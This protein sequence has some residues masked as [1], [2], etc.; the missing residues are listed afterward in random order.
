MPDASHHRRTKRPAPPGGLRYSRDGEKGYRREPSGKSFAY[1]DSGDRRV[2]DEATLERI[3]SLAIPPAWTRVWICGDERGHLQ[4]TGRDAR[5][6]KQYRYHP[7]WRELRDADKFDHLIEFAKAL[8][9]IRRQA[10]SDIGAAGLPRRKVLALLVELLE[11]T[12]IRVGN[13]RYAEENE[14]FGLTTMRNRHVKV[15]GARIEFQFRGKSGKFHR[16]ALDDPKLARIV[17]RIRELPGQELFQYLDEAGEVQSVGSSDVNEYLKEIS[18]RDV[19]TKDFRTWAGS[20]YV[21]SLLRRR[22]SVGITHV[23]A[24]VREASRQLGNTPAICRKSY[25]HPRVLDPKTW[26]ARHV[27]G[28]S[29]SPRGLRVEEAAFL[30]II[31]PLKPASRTVRPRTPIP[32]RAAPRASSDRP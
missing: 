21:A 28:A 10:R 14:S 9:R 1:L 17:R 12:C 19:S 3:R 25:V 2:D 8:P 18:G 6:R 20:V 22:S 32:R 11:R 30:A 31:R 16:I 29:R 27:R 24:A 15:E 13:E 26:R 4:A 23:A 7:R 5:G